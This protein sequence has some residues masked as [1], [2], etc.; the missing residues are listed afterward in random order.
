MTGLRTVLARALQSSPTGESRSGSLHL[1]R[2]KTIF[3]FKGHCAERDIMVGTAAAA[4]AALEKSSNRR[5]SKCTCVHSCGVDRTTFLQ[6]RQTCEMF[7]GAC[8]S[9]NGWI[10][11]DERT[12]GSAARKTNTRSS[13]GMCITRGLDT[14]TR[15]IFS[16]RLVGGEL[17]EGF[18][19]GNMCIYAIGH[20]CVANTFMTG[21]GHPGGM[22][23][24]AFTVTQISKTKIMWKQQ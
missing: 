10:P 24:I 3:R 7:S 16:L 13:F 23:P 17:H 21:T 11:M 15:S 8:V 5:I 19:S 18:A 12:C 9:D 22:V 6:C 2:Q 4:T 20:S 1:P 14:L